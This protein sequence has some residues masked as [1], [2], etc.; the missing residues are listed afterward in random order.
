MQDLENQVS[1]NGITL[2]CCT[3]RPELEIYAC[4]AFRKDIAATWKEVRAHPR[5]K[6]G[7]SEPLLQKHGH[8][9]RPGKG[10]DLMIHKST[11]NL[12]RLF[13]LCPELQHLRNRIATYL[14]K[15]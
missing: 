10:R 2:F 6:E 15:N 5:L 1:T 8:P 13:Q 7:I 9:Q 12:Q 3:A 14:Q 4:A 11:K